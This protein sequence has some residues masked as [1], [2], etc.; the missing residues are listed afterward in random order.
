MLYTAY[1]YKYG[2]MISGNGEIYRPTFSHIA[3]RPKAEGDK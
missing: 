3:S 2:L 1:M